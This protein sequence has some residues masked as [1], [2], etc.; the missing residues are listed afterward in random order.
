M[1]GF[2]LC[3]KAM[4]KMGGVALQP[5]KNHDSKDKILSIL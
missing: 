2:A 4:E 1:F 5:E 3:F